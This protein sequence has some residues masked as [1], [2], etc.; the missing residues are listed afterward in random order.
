MKMMLIYKTLL[1]SYFFKE[2]ILN[3]KKMDPRIK[4]N[5]QKIYIYYINI[6]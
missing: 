1:I 6:V 3:L 5:Q 4:T 2:I